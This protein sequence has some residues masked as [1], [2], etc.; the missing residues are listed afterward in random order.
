MMPHGLAYD[1]KLPLDGAAEHPVLLVVGEILPLHEF[2]DSAAGVDDVPQVGFT[3]TLRHTGFLAAL[4]SPGAD[5]GF[6]RH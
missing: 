1:G 3:A 4:R 6:G 5:K 2:D